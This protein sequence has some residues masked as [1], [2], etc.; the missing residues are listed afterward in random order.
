MVAV[1]AACRKALVNARWAIVCLLA[2]TGIENAP[3]TL[4][5][6]H[7]WHFRQLLVQRSVLW[8][9]DLDY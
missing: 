1:A 3:F 2:I 4:Y 8:W 5:K 6:L 7:F 9:E